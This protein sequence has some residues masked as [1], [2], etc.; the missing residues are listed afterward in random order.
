ME[1]DYIDSEWTLERDGNKLKVPIGVDCQINIEAQASRA[2]FSKRAEK[3]YLAELGI[4]GAKRLREALHL[5]PGR[6]NSLR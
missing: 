4:H 5:R 1:I 6:A 2:P 3:D